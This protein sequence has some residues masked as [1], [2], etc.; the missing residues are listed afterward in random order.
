MIVQMVEQEAVSAVERE[1]EAFLETYHHC[2]DDGDDEDR[3]SRG[4]ARDP[5]PRDGVTAG[6]QGRRPPRVGEPEDDEHRDLERVERP[7]RE[8]GVCP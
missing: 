8:H 7:A 3:Q 4:E 5:D 2:K 1:I 6:A